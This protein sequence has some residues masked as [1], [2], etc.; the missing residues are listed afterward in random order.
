MNSESPSL[1]KRLIVALIIS[2]ALTGLLTGLLTLGLAQTTPERDIEDKIPKHV[3]IKVKIKSDKE[4]AVKDLKNQKWLRDLELEVTNTSDRPIYFLELWIILPEVISDGG[5]PV[6]FTL[7]Y[8]RSEFIDFKTLALPEDV[9]I[10]PGERY[11]YTIAENYQKGWESRRGRNYKTDPRKVQITFTQLSF[12]DGSGFNGSHAKPYPYKKEISKGGA[13]R[14]GPKQ[15]AD[16]RIVHDVR[17]PL[18]SLKYSFA[19]TPVAFLPVSFFFG[20]NNRNV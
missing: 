4:K 8:G 2:L 20:E 9:P 14:E 19:S 7:R 13:C 15:V 10:Q 3:P 16:E 17:F 6:G 11:V 12:G 5:K 1:P 18:Q